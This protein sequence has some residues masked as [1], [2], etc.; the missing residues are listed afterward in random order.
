MALPPRAIRAPILTRGSLVA[1]IETATKPVQPTPRPIRRQLMGQTMQ[2][3][4]FPSPSVGLS[5]VL[6]QSS[7]SLRSVSSVNWQSDD[8]GQGRGRPELNQAPSRRDPNNVSSCL[9]SPLWVLQRLTP[10]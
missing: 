5:Q 4:V 7:Q 1:E 9:F 2:C 8:N 6:R 3:S 10:T